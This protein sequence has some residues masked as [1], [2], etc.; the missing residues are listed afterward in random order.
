MHNNCYKN[1]KSAKIWL[2]GSCTGSE[3]FSEEMKAGSTEI[4]ILDSTME[5]KSVSLCGQSQAAE[6][7]N[8]L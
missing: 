8:Q 3:I 5:G 6:G 1:H 4:A 2:K 7:G